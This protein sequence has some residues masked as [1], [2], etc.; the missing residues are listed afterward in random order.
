M[1]YP[2]LAA[3]LVAALILAACSS[4]EAGNE[5]AVAGDESLAPHMSDEELT[6]VPPPPPLPG[7]NETDDQGGDGSDDEVATAIPARFHGEWN[8][9]LSACGTG[10]S[11]TRLRI[12]ADRLR[13]YESAGEVREV[14]VVS[15]RLIEVTATYSGEGQ[16]WTNERQLSLS[17]DGDTL[18]VTG[19][20]AT[21][22]RSRCP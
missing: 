6:E 12:G 1:R 4:E 9:D 3:P 13:F 11:E 20:G 2:T 16:T 19:D 7:Q 10:A 21:M 15:D 14:D 22:T 8:Q 17:P 5:A 18:T